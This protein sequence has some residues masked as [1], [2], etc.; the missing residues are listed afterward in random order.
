M[1]KR[2]FRA[3]VAVDVE[4]GTLA[5]DFGEGKPFT[6]D[7]KKIEPKYAELSPN[8]KR[9]ALHGL[10]QKTGDS[11]AAPA[12]EAYHEVRSLFAEREKGVWSQRA[13]SGGPRVTL[14]AIAI[15]NLQARKAAN[16][17]NNLKITA[18]DDQISAVVENL[19]KLA[20]TEA[21]SVKL[22]NG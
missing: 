17:P 10:R 3:K 15:A 14:L 19:D 11:Y 13:E 22:E 9:L 16:E 4:N 8:G 6:A 20:E 5:Y 1:A 7:I 18:T 2:N 21:V 12:S